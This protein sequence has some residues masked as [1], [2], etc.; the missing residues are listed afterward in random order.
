MSG[1]L[2]PQEWDVL[3]YVASYIAG[4]EEKPS[5]QKLIHA[6]LENQAVNHLITQGLLKEENGHLHPVLERTRLAA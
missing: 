5:K 4:Y 3:L 1:R 6:G 2:T